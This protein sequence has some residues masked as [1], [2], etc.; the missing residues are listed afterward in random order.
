MTQ[1]EIQ[2]QSQSPGKL[3]IKSSD[4]TCKRKPLMSPLKE[5]ND[6]LESLSLNKKPFHVNEHNWQSCQSTVRDRNSVMFNSDLMSDVQ[7]IVGSTN[8]QKIPAHKYV[9][10]TGS[11]VFYAMFYGTMAEIT[12]EIEVPDIEPSAFLAL[13]KYTFLMKTKIL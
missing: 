6:N 2:A 3:P 7:F 4:E 12:D 1:Q 11:S 5:I 8:K 10:A 9:L 13:L